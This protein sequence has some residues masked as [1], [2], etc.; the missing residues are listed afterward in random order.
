MSAYLKRHELVPMLS[1][2]QAAQVIASRKMPDGQSL[3][4]YHALTVS[5]CGVPFVFASHGQWGD[6]TE[7]LLIDNQQK[8]AVDCFDG[9]TDVDGQSLAESIRESITQWIA[10]EFESNKVKRGQSGLR[11]IDLPIVNDGKKYLAEFECSCCGEYF[12][13]DLDE[14]LS[15]DQDHGFAWCKTCQHTF[16]LG[17]QPEATPAGSADVA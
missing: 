10:T 9:D 16:R 4:N 14:G 5:V 6:W 3:Y 2:V 11:N 15:H 13:L 8:L 12:E 7:F 1:F 17:F